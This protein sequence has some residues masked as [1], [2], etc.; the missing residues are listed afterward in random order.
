M[1]GGLI[2]RALFCLDLYVGSVY[3]GGLIESS[4]TSADNTQPVHISHLLYLIYMLL[5]YCSAA[6]LHLVNA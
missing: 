4:W 1:P 5:S 3:S 2:Y 6:A